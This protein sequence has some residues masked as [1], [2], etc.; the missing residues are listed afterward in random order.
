MRID[1]GRP[2]FTLTDTVQVL[3]DGFDVFF[4]LEEEG[5]L[6]CL[7]QFVHFL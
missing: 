2:I 4:V 3:E 7:A 5:I 6:D 1:S